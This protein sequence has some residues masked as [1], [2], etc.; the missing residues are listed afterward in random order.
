MSDHVVM[1]IDG[2]SV[3]AQAGD[4]V[5]TAAKRAGLTIPGLCSS[6]HLA[7]FG[8]C[9]LCV[10]E[11][12]G[13]KGLPASCTTPVQAGMVVHTQTDRL[14]RL[15]RN[16]TELL[17]SEQPS[18]GSLPAALHELAQS[19]GLDHVR[20]RQPTVRDQVRDS[21]NPFFAFDNA[22]CISCA[23][24]VRVCD[25]IQGT[26]ALTMVGRGFG[27]RPMAGAAFYGDASTGF[28]TSN[29]VSCGACVK[30]CP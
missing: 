21:S 19:V 9:R 1:T 16:I 2:R 17:L 26:F 3:S 8:S 4:T 28:A 12:E 29:C 22:S 23:R 13:Q 25:E 30:E 6:E 11:V 20:Y 15:R 7:P 18:N 24:C 14:I 10:C 5:F 27:T